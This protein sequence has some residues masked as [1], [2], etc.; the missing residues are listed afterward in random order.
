[1]ILTF[2]GTAGS[3]KTTLTAKFGQ[4]LEK[5]GHN[6]A[7]INLDTGVKS[8]PYTP[9]VDV[10]EMI[11]V[12]QLMKSGLGPNGAIVKSYDILTPHAKEYANEI[13][14]LEEEFDYVLIDTPGQMESFLFHDF[15][16]NLME[17]LREPLVVYLFDPNILKNLYDY[18][19]VRF[20]ALMI[21]LRLSATTIPALNKIDII[22]NELEYYKKYLDNLEYLSSRLRLDPST[23]GYLAYKLCS[24]LPDVISSVRLL[25]LSAISG[26]GFEELE[27][28]AY[29]HY[30]TCGDLT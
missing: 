2:I 3:G 17:N 25:Y 24:F 29:E 15:G 9:H 5:E 26:A 19:F 28:V 12:E 10:R 23:Q 22:K 27:T 11:T 16:S 1:M 13:S 21:D 6:V 8:L 7:Y 30:C 14:K 20:F 4:Y 18:C